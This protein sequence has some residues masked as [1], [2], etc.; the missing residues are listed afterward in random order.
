LLLTVACGL[1]Q[2]HKWEFFCIVGSIAGRMGLVGEQN[3]MNHMGV[4]I[5]PVAQFQPAVHVRMLKMLNV[6]DAVWIHSF[7]V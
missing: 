7:C 1:S 5:N 6:M 2:S 3:V 4:R